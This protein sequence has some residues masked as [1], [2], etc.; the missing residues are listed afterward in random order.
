MAQKIDFTKLVGAGN[1][2]VLIDNRRLK[3]YLKQKLS[4][5][6]KEMCDRKFGIGADGLLIW[7]NVKGAAARMRIFN[8]DGSEAEMC[9]NGGRCFALYV[10]RKIKGIKS[11]FEV[12]TMAGLVKAQVNKDGVRIQLTDPKQM[13]FNMPLR[14]NNRSIRVNFINT[15]VPHTVIFVQDLD[16]IAVA[17]LGRQIRYHKDFAPAGTNVDFVEIEDKDSIRIRT[18]ERG[19]EGETL[20][21]GTG[22]TAAALVT[23]EKLSALPLKKINVITK[24][25]EVLKVHFEREESSFKNVW[26]E[27]KARIVY[28]GVYYV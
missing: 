1:D 27:G 5:L 11:C 9:G 7:D 25:N 20:A 15:G 8:S 24:S 28:Q 22:A 13:K 12:K 23:A 26:L 2:F 4:A 6:A 18:Y 21:C 17:Q 3:I 16:N 19:V 14:L 10:S